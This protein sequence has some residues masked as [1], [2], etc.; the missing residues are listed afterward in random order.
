MKLWT[1]VTWF[2]LLFFLY[3]LCTTET[4]SNWICRLYCVHICG[5]ISDLLNVRWR[6]GNRKDKIFGSERNMSPRLTEKPDF[7]RHPYK[8][9]PRI[10]WIDIFDIFLRKSVR[11]NLLGKIWGM[12]EGRFTECSQGE[13]STSHYQ[14]DDKRSALYSNKITPLVEILG[15]LFSRW[16]VFRQHKL[17]AFVGLWANSHIHN[18]HNTGSRDFNLKL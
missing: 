2:N 15:A 13:T 5:H 16:N 6:G 17:I 14:A 18:F 11:H 3:S 7:Q 1:R 9:S 8:N 4:T 12:C 10:E